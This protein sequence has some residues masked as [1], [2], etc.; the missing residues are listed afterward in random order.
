M[1]EERKMKQGESVREYFL[2]MKEIASRGNIEDNALFQYVI[3]GIKDNNANKIILYGAKNIREFKDKLKC[4][5]TIFEKKNAKIYKEHKK[6]ENQN[7]EMNKNKDKNDL[8]CFNCGL[9]GHKSFECKNKEKGVKC[10]HCNKFGHIAND[11]PEKSDQKSN[12]RCVN[13]T[14]FMHKEIKIGKKFF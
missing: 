2:N 9:K 6:Y 4:Y 12:V 5:E 3:E 7:K 14:D 10:F 11:C 1:L 13:V 8:K